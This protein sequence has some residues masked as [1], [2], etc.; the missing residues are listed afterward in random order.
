MI[1]IRIAP[2]FLNA[3]IATS[4]ARAQSTGSTTPVSLSNYDAR[5]VIVPPTTP[6]TVLSFTLDSTTS[7][8]EMFDIL[9]SDPGL[10]VSIIMPGGGTVTATN[11]SSQGFQYFQQTVDYNSTSGTTFLD[12]A[13]VHNVF[14]CPPGL[15]AGTYQVK[16]D[17]TG[18][19]TTSVLQA[20]FTSQSTVLIGISA[21]Q[22]PFVQGN[23]VVLTGIL[24]DGSNPIIGATAQANVFNFVSVAG[25]VSLGNYQLVNQQQIDSQTV[26]AN[27]LVSASNSGTT[28]RGV[29]AS[30][31][32]SSSNLI[33]TGTPSVS[34]GDLT[35]STATSSTNYFSIILTNAQQFDPS[36]LNWT[37][38]AP[39]PPTMVTLQDSGPNDAAPGDG[40]YT[41]TITPTSPGEYFV[42]L[43][44]TGLS[45]SGVP[46][47]RTSSTQFTVSL[48]SATLGSIT[49][50]V[51]D[52]N[53]NGLWDRLLVTAAVSVQTS[54]SYIF[55][56]AL[57]ASNGQVIWTT[58]TAA[59]TTGPGQV[60]AT[61]QSGSIISLGV[62]GP[63]EIVGVAL[64]LDGSPQ[65]VAGQ[66]PD[67]GPTAAY[68]L[69]S[70][71]PGAMYFI[72]SITATGVDTTNS[73]Y[74]DILR[75]MVGVYSPAGSCSW[76]GALTDPTGALIDRY[77]G[78][79]SFATTGNNTA[80]FDFSGA[81]IAQSGMNGPYTLTE[82]SLTCGSNTVS[83]GLQLTTQA[84]SAAQFHLVL[85]GISL[86][87]DAPA[88]TI[89]S[90]GLRDST[91]SVASTG[92]FQ[93][94]ANLSISGLP[95]GITATFDLPAI[96][97]PGGSPLEI[98]VGSS[99]VPGIYPLTVTAT[100]GSLSGSTPIS[101]TVV[102]PDFVLSIP[103]GAIS[104]APSSQVNATV[105]ITPANTF[106][107]TVSLSTSGLPAGAVASFL[108]ATVSGGSPST[109]TV[110]IATNGVVA[111]S[112]PFTITGTS[113]TL[114]HSISATLVV[115]PT[116]LPY[117][118]VTLGIGTNS[119]G[120]MA[121]HSSGEISVSAPGN[122]LSGTSDSFQFVFQPLSGDGALIG[123]IEQ[124]QNATGIAMAG[125]MIR[126]TLDP[127]ASNV[128]LGL[129]AG[130][131]AT[132]QSRT[133]AGNP[134]SIS[135]L[136]TLSVPY[137]FELV[138]VGNTFTAYTSPDGINWNQQGSVLTVS[139]ASSVF[140]GLALSSDV[141]GPAA[142]AVFDHALVAAGP[143]F[144][145][146]DAQPNVRT[147]A[148]N[149]TSVT[150]ATTVE[151]VSSFSGTV[152]LAALGLP[153]GAT[154]SFSASS[155]TGFGGSLLTVNAG[156]VA[157]GTYPLFISATSGSSV[158]FTP[159]TL[160]VSG[161][162]ITG[163]QDPWGSQ[164][165]GTEASGTGTAFSN[166]V[167]AVSGSGQSIASTVDG[168][169]FE[170]QALVG[171]GT[172]LAR[173]VSVQNERTASRFG[174][175]M[176]E[177]LDPSAPYA[178]M[179][180]SNNSGDQLNLLGR[181]A[182]AGTPASE[183]GASVT[184]PY[185][186]KLVRA[187]NTFTGFASPDGI[188]WTQIG[189]TRTVAM[190]SVVFVGLAVCSGDPAQV[191]VVNFDTVTVS[192]G[193]DF[194]LFATPTARTIPVGSAVYYHTV[195]MLA[196]SG[197]FGSANLTI[198]GLPTGVSA[199]LSVSSLSPG[200]FA[201]LQL[202]VTNS[203]AAGTYPITITG[204]AGSLSHSVVIN[205]T[206]TA[207]G[208]ILPSPWAADD[209][210][211]A[212]VPGTS[213]L[214]PG[215]ALIQASGA[216]LNTTSDSFR[217]TYQ[218]MT[219][220]GTMIIR[221]YN[222]LT[223]WDGA[224]N[225][226]MIRESLLPD[227]AYAYARFRADV[228]VGTLLTQYAGFQYRQSEG[229]APVAS[230]TGV[231]II[232]YWF[233][234]VRAG[235]VF[236]GYISPDGINWTKSGASVTIN[237]PQT[238]FIGIAVCSGNNTGL[239]T[240]FL[241]SENLV[242]G[243]DFG[244][245][246][247]PASQTVPLGRGIGYYSAAIA[248]YNGLSSPITLSTSGLPAGATASFNPATIMGT[249]ISTVQ[250]V[251]SP[252]VAAGTYPFQITGTS[253]ALSRSA[254]ATLV[255]DGTQTS[256]PSPWNYDFIG[257]GIPSGA[258][259]ATVS[260]GVYTLT[261]GQCCVAAT[262]D[263]TFF[264]H[265]TLSGNGTM[266]GRLTA[267]SGS[268]TQAGI[269][270]RNS[271]DPASPG[272]M[273]A[274]T[275]SLTVSQ[276]STSGGTWAIVATA[277]TFN[278]PY[279][280]KISK[281]GSQV[282]VFVSPDGMQWL[283]IAAPFATNLSSS[284]EVGMFG[285]G[286]IIF[287]NVGLAGSQDLPISAFPGSFYSMNGVS[288]TINLTVFPSAG[289]ITSAPV[290][291]I[292]GL[293]SGVTAQFTASSI[294]D[295]SRNSQG[296]AN[297]VL[298]I[299]ASSAATPGVYPLVVTA[300]S[301]A[302]TG[303]ASITL[304]IAPGFNISNVQ[305]STSCCAPYTRT[306]IPT[307][308]YGTEPPQ[309]TQIEGFTFDLTYIGG[310]SSGVGFNYA[311][312][313]W[314]YP[315]SVIPNSVTSSTTS[316]LASNTGGSTVGNQADG[317]HWALI[318]A[319]GGGIT[320]NQY[321]M[322]ELGP[323]F[324]TGCCAGIAAGTSATSNVYISRYDN[325]TDPVTITAT[326][327]PSGL[328]LAFSP[329]PVNNIAN[330][331]VTIL[332]ET[333]SASVPPGSA[334]GSVVASSAS[335]THLVTSGV[336]VWG[337]SL[338]TTQ[339]SGS[340]VAGGH[341]TITGT[342]SFPANN[343]Y[344]S[345]VTFG[346]GTLPTGVTVSFSPTS[347]TTAGTTTIT[348]TTSTSTPAGTY[349]LNFIGTGNNLVNSAPPVTLVVTS[350]FGI[351][352]SALA[353]LN[354][355]S[356][357]TSTV[358]ISPLGGFSGPVALSISGLPAGATAV[359]NPANISGGSGTSTLTVTTTA[360]TLP[361]SST[362]VVTGTNGGLTHASNLT[363]SVKNFSLSVSPAS[364]TT[365]SGTVTSAYVVTLTMGNGYNSAVSFGTSG[366]PTGATASFSTT[367]RTS[368]GTTNLTITPSG[369]VAAGSY[370]FTII[371]TGPGGALVQSTSATLVI[372]ADF[373]ISVSPSAVTVTAA[374]GGVGDTVTVN[375]LGGYSTPVGLT[376]SGLPTGATGTFSTSPVT[377][378]GASTLTLSA[379][380][381]VAGGNYTITVTGT[382]GSVTHTQN[383]TLTVKNFSLSTSPT[384]IP[385]SAGSSGTSTA[386]LTMAGGYSSTVT[387]G[388]S[389]LPSGASATFSP[390]TRTNT[391]TTTVTIVTTGSVASGSYP[392]TISGTNGSLVQN[393]LATLVVSAGFSLTNSG[394]K[395]IVAASN[396]TATVTLTA[397]S[398]LTGATSL[399]VSGL[400]TNA[401]A[402]FN[403][404]SITGSGTSI[405]TITVPASVAGGASTLT[406]TGTNGSLTRTTTLTLTVQNFTL[407][408]S[409]STLTVTHGG[410]NVT[411]TTTLTM[412]GGFSSSVTFSATSLPSGVTATFSPTSRT[413]TGTTTVTIHAASSAT[414]GGSTINV[415]GTSGSLIQSIPIS[416]TVN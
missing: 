374:G 88:Q 171:D 407:A 318:T 272:V 228:I 331:D 373:S 356:S 410:S 224:S 400:P 189:T 61:F 93:G 182:A 213:T 413:T 380:S 102:V 8:T 33:I 339:P 208:S 351:A 54:G 273:I 86:S 46:F 34:F 340:V 30:V 229:A 309:N 386:T 303:S 266:V 328:S 29:T 335:V 281:Q 130:T 39:S 17:S 111:G 404:A 145:L 82:L 2:L 27:Y 64:V 231:G 83:S 207:T 70:F 282:T 106:S 170:Y 338:S 382:V 337:F 297:Q 240:A 346:T 289:S 379:A 146:S 148:P 199:T 183:T 118:W 162:S 312:D 40:L 344:P 105:T 184:E 167:Y 245:S 62:D 284:T 49:S 25:Q 5:S 307:G 101:L 113:G 94:A 416:L 391:G 115:N 20:V 370:P 305:P 114:T 414:L 317:I 153:T 196:V 302:A 147:S 396:G 100:S 109:S 261:S 91:V 256:L 238:V 12:I 47:S 352:A 258:F 315:I 260:G 16:A 163:P 87:V 175:M 368:S 375:S 176:R 160:V 173:V 216:D 51:V 59:L 362:L 127:G 125:V 361:G 348:I 63:Y 152:T 313:M 277:P 117:P 360:A 283:R 314:N 276:R 215:A 409:P 32:S 42:V 144:Y 28:L 186:L 108:P 274:L 242:I 192:S 133:G 372:T 198:S 21:G 334:F 90:G 98:V 11:A 265:Q 251:T 247:S 385:V 103:A 128:F 329:N 77:Y 223:I 405:M 75:V 378:G 159:L 288:A 358:T 155:I 135:G 392:F 66:N 287:D 10:A 37:I 169:R 104:V 252:S 387:F 19:S 166:G 412:T 270:I 233:K 377:P 120:G 296:I 222:W 3:V 320:T 69:S 79:A 200:T 381:T 139:M 134:Y 4:L 53:G 204:V 212:S 168:F 286:T 239:T 279:W 397:T 248:A 219:G 293:P 327:F 390:T 249:G 235:N 294:T 143:D 112:Y 41:G 142:A 124:T 140:A 227:A 78:S 209:I 304:N 354:A 84:F 308:F 85:A 194:Y 271:L 89:I 218:V 44:A 187:G 388:T 298:K 150:F 350:D 74:F 178:A 310:F 9:V 76:I 18:V 205:L 295:F 263:Q 96:P 365:P 81:K 415:V 324:Q 359:F 48:P 241:D 366:L 232:P 341:T 268:P 401:S 132:L 156:S 254:S 107:G 210:G 369:S 123:R 347:R 278:S 172:I 363:L 131:T 185:W 321:I 214:S 285:N 197:S 157:V 7:G 22:P 95:S 191:T 220:D 50:S 67:S 300:V 73:G 181:S 323:D 371:G 253:G 332:S 246:S 319:F 119:A 402:S 36:L 1:R 201:N 15:A 376:I 14:A 58:A 164:D 389:G 384:N 267:F 230:E 180:I 262:A 161:T 275:T 110:N 237:M 403:P 257:T 137:W 330:P 411:S 311:T 165:I 43:R 206:V 244:L 221:N 364:Q 269:M 65:V 349:M 121:T 395:T 211:Q 333:A 71:D 35:T 226:V 116:A 141:S 342:L 136:G 280:M 154:A 398:D 383:M 195:K 406:I 72:G 174:L 52:D 355:A 55:S 203:V 177:S 80:E 188:N 202:S 299:T 306:A 60:Q 326:G 367:S 193:A 316:I 149:N 45:A 259:G 31:S 250:V 158:R 24:L 322:T 56:A 408:T 236:S 234:V 151:A 292:G 138:R 264:A 357:T 99:A 38:V 290:Y 13:G 129:S 6:S 57:Q 301:G 92:A 217:Y 336:T 291:S 243:P 23:P 399:A 179:L 26:Q 255:V 393:T 97:V 345:A 68:P 126:E 325:H 353:S 225:G 190:S 343:Y 394:N 122:S